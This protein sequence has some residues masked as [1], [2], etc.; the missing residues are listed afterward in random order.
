MEWDGVISDSSFRVANLYKMLTVFIQN[1]LTRFS[2]DFLAERPVGKNENPELVMFVSDPFRSRA[3]AD[4]EPAAPAE[5][6]GGCG[7]QLQERVSPRAPREPGFGRGAAALRVALRALCSIL[8]VVWGC[9]IVEEVLP[10]Q[11]A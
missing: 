4:G 2:I 5:A 7:L 6:R 11:G 1:N 9:A 8:C 10:C 3:G